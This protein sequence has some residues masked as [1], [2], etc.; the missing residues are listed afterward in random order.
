MR[1]LHLLEVTF[2][3]LQLLPALR[4]FQL[5]LPSKCL[6]MGTVKEENPSQKIN[7]N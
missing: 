3:L 5:D 2:E 6:G 1:H 7:N 4:D